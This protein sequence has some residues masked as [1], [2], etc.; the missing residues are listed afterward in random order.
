MA[1]HSAKSLLR[2]AAVPVG[3]VLFHDRLKPAQGVACRFGGAP[4]PV[5]GLEDLA[6]DTL[7]LSNLDEGVLRLRGVP[8]PWIKP[9][10]F[11]GVSLDTVIEELG[12]TTPLTGEAA[13]TAASDIAEIGNRTLRL[14]LERYAPLYSL[15]VATPT[16]LPAQLGQQLHGQPTILSNSADTATFTALNSAFLTT[17]RAGYPGDLRVRPYRLRFARTTHTA[18]LLQHAVPGMN[19]YWQPYPEPIPSRMQPPGAGSDLYRF[20]VDLGT[21]YTALVRLRVGTISNPG[22]AHAIDPLSPD[23]VREWYSVQEAVFLAA[24]AS[25]QILQVLVGPEFTDINS[26]SSWRLPDDSDELGVSFSHGLACHLHWLALASPLM[27]QPNPYAPPQRQ[28]TPI[29]VWLTSWNRLHYLQAAERLHQDTG[30]FIS[31]CG[32]DGIEVMLQPSQLA[33]VLAACPA[34]HLI[35]SPRLLRD[36]QLQESA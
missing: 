33:P 18:R 35:P 11:L 13:A 17:R 31:S 12:Y 7:W 32:T 8:F 14:V 1:T 6:T 34:L 28:A 2:P 20:L 3:C 25:V 30:A 36:A 29:G 4:Q 16:P 5:S 19:G 26:N 22:F 10:H 9:L 24:R 27:T 15:R 23:N 21:R